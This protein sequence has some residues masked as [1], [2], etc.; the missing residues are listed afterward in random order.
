MGSRLPIRGRVLL[1][2]KRSLQAHCFKGQ[3]FV[4]KDFRHLTISATQKL[5]ADDRKA[6]AGQCGDRDEIDRIN[7]LT[8]PEERPIGN[9]V[10][11]HVPSS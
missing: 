4:A 11:D 1:D 7:R 9:W 10:S 8:L 6:V 3:L 2:K 5:A